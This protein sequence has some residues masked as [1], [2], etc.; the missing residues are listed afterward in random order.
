M[1]AAHRSLSEGMGVAAADAVADDVGAGAEVAGDEALHDAC[2]FAGSGIPPPA[3]ALRTV[4][5]SV[6]PFEAANGSCDD[7]SDWSDSGGIA[8][9][10]AIAAEIIAGAGGEG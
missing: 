9:P 5:F 3:K 10:R 7:D 2:H 6:Q 8:L 4:A 1:A